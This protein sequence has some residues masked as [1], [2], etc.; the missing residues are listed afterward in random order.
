MFD[1]GSN[2]IQVGFKFDKD[3]AKDDLELLILSSSL[4]Q[5]S[6]QRGLAAVL[7]LQLVMGYLTPFS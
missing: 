2:V 6:S 4:V 3:V 5:V 7:T 1:T